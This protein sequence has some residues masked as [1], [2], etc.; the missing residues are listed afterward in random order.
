LVLHRCYFYAQFWTMYRLINIA[1]LVALYWEADSAYCL[2]LAFTLL[3]YVV[4]PYATLTRAH[5][6]QLTTTTTTPTTT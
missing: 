4:P 1:I 2:Y 3:V 6:H 5:T